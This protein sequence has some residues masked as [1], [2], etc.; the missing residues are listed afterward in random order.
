M[1]ANSPSA[2]LERATTRDTAALEAVADALLDSVPN[3][4]TRRAYA[5]ALHDLME[6][7]ASSGEAALQKATVQRYVSELRDA[8]LSASNINQR[9][10]AIRK[11]A[12]WAAE[13]GA[14]GETD[15]NAIRNIG[16]IRAEATSTD[17]WLTR[18][19]ALGLLRLPDTSSLKGL[20]DRALLAILVGCGL[21]RTEAAQ[22]TFD[23]IHQRDGRWI[24]A[25]VEGPRDKRRAVPMPRWAKDAVDDWAEAAGLADGYVLR[26]VAR[27]GHVSGDGLTDQTIADVVGHYGRLMEMDDLSAHD[28]RRTFAKLAHQGGASLRQIQLSLG[29]GSLR[30]TERYLGTEQDLVDAPCDRLG[31]AI[32]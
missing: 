22:L 28:L 15:A 32:E 11:L 31:L 29:H 3:E 25:Q 16:G 26:R 27:G 17:Q 9:L 13:E 4:H 7:Y 6:W 12:A 10:S 1:S 19:Q 8:G 23:Q 5:R 30:T 14:L 2:Q 20:R 24:L 18:E 21:R